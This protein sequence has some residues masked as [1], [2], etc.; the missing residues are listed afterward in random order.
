MLLSPPAVDRGLPG[1][2]FQRKAGPA[3]PGNAGPG[4]SQNH[5]GLPDSLKSGVEAISGMSLDDVRVH[6]NSARPAQLRAFAYTQGTQIHVGPGQERHLPHEAWHV[7][8]QKQGRVAPTLQK[9]GMQINDNQGL[10]HE[11]DVMGARATDA[12]RVQAIQPDPGF[13]SSSNVVQMSRTKVKIGKG[14]AWYWTSNLQINWGDYVVPVHPCHKRQ[15]G[16]DDLLGG[17]TVIDSAGT[18]RQSGVYGPYSPT[19][20]KNKSGHVERK[21]F[22]KMQDSLVAEMEDDDTY[23]DDALAVVEINQWY[24]PCSGTQ[25]CTN[26]LNDQV[27]YLNTLYNEVSACGRFQAQQLYES[28]LSEMHPKHPKLKPEHKKDLKSDEMDIEGGEV[29]HKN[30]KPL[31]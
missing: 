13:V 14:P 3:M 11:A 29:V 2:V 10:E 26:F 20:G 7:V 6:Y 28:G 24:T 31:Y 19:T 12:R 21:F 17:W 22:R 18:Y 27:K 30:V 23:N 16:R 8:Q 15:V 4:H 5:T 25:G 9:K 1:S